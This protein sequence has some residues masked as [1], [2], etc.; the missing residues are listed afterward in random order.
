M[1]GETKELLC[2]KAVFTLS[3]SPARPSRIYNL[4]SRIFSSKC[5]KIH[6]INSVDS[7]RLSSGIEIAKEGS[8]LPRK[9][10][11]HRPWPG[12]LPR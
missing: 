1:R 5:T 7:T 10:H 9:S 11:W 2:P 3:L 6:Y 4:K 12:S 8:L